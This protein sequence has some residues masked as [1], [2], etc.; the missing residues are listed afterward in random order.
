MGPGR[1]PQ[2]TRAH[3]G[4]EAVGCLQNHVDQHFTHG[5]GASSCQIHAQR[6]QT[7]PPEPAVELF[8]RATCMASFLP[9]AQTVLKIVEIRTKRDSVNPELQPRAVVEY[10]DRLDGV[11]VAKTMTYE[12]KSQRRA[13]E[14]CSLRGLKEALSIPSEGA[15]LQRPQI[16]Q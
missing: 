12:E 3:S 5:C 8:S 15:L 9:V 11:C 10:L 13:A 4:G 7:Q 2:Y 1:N 14:S 6:A 16:L